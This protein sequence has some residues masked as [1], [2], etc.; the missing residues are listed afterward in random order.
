MRNFC[1]LAIVLAVLITAS[2]RVFALELGHKAGAVTLTNLDGHPRMMNHYGD[3][4]GTVVVFLSARCDTTL[5]ELDKLKAASREED[6]ESILFV[7]I[8]SNPAETGEELKGFCQNHGMVFP[9]YRDPEGKA[10]KQFGATQTPEFFLL[11]KDGKLRYHGAVAG[12][13]PALDAL[14]AGAAI[15]TKRSPVSGTPIHNPN[16]K[17]ASEDPYGSISFSSELVFNRIPGAPAHH[18]STLTEAPNGDVLCLW[19]G[20]SYESAEDQVLF[21]ARLKKGERTWS[22]PEVVVR[23][24]DQ[25]PGNAIIFKDTTN[26]LW[27]V[28]GQM[29]GSRPTRRGSGWSSCRLMSRISSDNGYTWN[30]ERAWP[31]KTRMLPRNPPIVLRDGT[32]VLPMSIDL[33]PEKPDGTL[34]RL[35][36]DG[37]NWKRLGIMRRGEQITVVQRADGSLLGLARSRPFILQSE[38]ADGGVT[39]T[40]PVP[41]TLKCPDSG[42]VMIRLKSGRLLLAHN[43]NDGEDRATLALEVSDDE[44]ATWKDKKILEMEPDLGAGEY[45]YP[46]LLQTSDDMIHITYTCRRYAIKHV[47]FD[48]GWLLR[49]ER[50]N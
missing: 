18:C 1:T 49:L 7:G 45:S 25:P 8:C 2:T 41:T 13:E 47:A 11:D 37:V 14:T 23:N 28:W 40:R 39:W 16:P 27:M 21:L 19:Y 22:T 26:R 31:D 30:E 34:L 4:T 10:A 24:P 38:S 36:P 33:V 32:L 5:A 12:L 20:G 35:E 3:H 17:R 46:C 29:E 15:A 43:D 9:V 6:Y 50:P 42:I 48:E 44:G